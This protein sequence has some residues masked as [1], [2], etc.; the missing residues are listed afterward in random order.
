MLAYLFAVVKS[1]PFYL[2]QGFCM[3]THLH[4]AIKTAMYYPSVHTS[5]VF[6]VLCSTFNCRVLI[7]KGYTPSCALA[8]TWNGC[9]SLGLAVVV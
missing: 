2:P 1:F 9:H 6:A 4:L 8:N 3:S 7:E 5:Q